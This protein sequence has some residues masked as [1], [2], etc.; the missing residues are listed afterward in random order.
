MPRENTTAPTGAQMACVKQARKAL[1]A[2][3]CSSC[4]CRPGTWA[5]R[6]DSTQEMLE[7]ARSSFRCHLPTRRPGKAPLCRGAVARY[8]TEEQVRALLSVPVSTVEALCVVGEEG[9]CGHLHSSIPEALTCLETQRLTDPRATVAKAVAASAGGFILPLD[10]DR[11]VLAE[12][13]VVWR[14]YWYVL[15]HAG[16]CGHAHWTPETAMIC[17][18]DNALIV[19]QTSLQRH[20]R[21]PIRTDDHGGEEDIDAI[22]LGDDFSAFIKAAREGVG[23]DR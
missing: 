15:D 5:Q 12:H 22:L 7:A 21:W 4:A 9:V 19:G 18:L 10:A 11:H 20:D 16:D 23:G 3:S 1:D 2:Q 17:L 14:P 6:D 13:G 8:G